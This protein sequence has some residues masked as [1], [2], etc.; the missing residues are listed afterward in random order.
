[1]DKLVITKGRISGKRKAFS[2][3]VVNVAFVGDNSRF[4][5]PSYAPV[6]YL[7]GLEITYKIYKMD[8]PLIA[9]NTPVERP[10]KRGESNG[11]LQYVEKL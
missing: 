2:N 7:F 11:I 4:P 10:Q 1:M 5:H 9:R 6:L 8:S 3:D